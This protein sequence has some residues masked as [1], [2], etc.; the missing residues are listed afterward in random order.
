MSNVQV[1]AS[2]LYALLDQVTELLTICVKLNQAFGEV[3]ESMQP[4][5]SEIPDNV[6]DFEGKRRLHKD[7][8]EV[9]NKGDD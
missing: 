6:I 2:Q 9:Y 1:D 5:T 7:P 8:N 4:V 3:V